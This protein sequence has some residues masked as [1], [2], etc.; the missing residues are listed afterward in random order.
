MSYQVQFSGQGPLTEKANKLLPQVG[1]TLLARFDTN[2]A[3]MTQRLLD[4]VPLVARSSFDGQSLFHL[5]I[6][7]TTFLWA[8]LA[9]S[10]FEGGFVFFGLP[11]VRGQW[12]NPRNEAPHKQ[13]DAWIHR[14][15]YGLGNSLTG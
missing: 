10:E 12:S 3:P 14:R 9:V 2:P 15:Q 8:T 7:G 6:S 4:E 11:L 13:E 1:M 5:E